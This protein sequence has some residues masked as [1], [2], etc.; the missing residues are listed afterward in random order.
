LYRPAHASGDRGSDVHAE[1]WCDGLCE[2]RFAARRVA[3]YGVVV[4]VDGALRDLLCAVVGESEAMSSNVAEYAAG[5]AAV[6]WLL[7][8]ARG[9]TR[10]TVRSDSLLMIRQVRGEWAVRGGRSAPLHALLRERAALLPMPVAWEW[11]PREQNAEADALTRKAYRERGPREA[12]YDYVAM[13]E[14]FLELTGG[15]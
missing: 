4:R 1:L 2:P 14:R 3:T 12:R 10:A 13:V 7:A 15:A 8:H 11:V 5:I 9:V 6:E